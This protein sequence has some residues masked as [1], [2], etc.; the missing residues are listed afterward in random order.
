MELHLESISRSIRSARA[1][2]RHRAGA[3]PAETVRTAELLTSEL[4]TNAVKYGPPDGS[5]TV[6][7][8]N[9]SGVLDVSVSDESHRRPELRTPDPSEVGGRGLLMVDALASDWGVR[10]HPGDG[11][12]VWFRLRH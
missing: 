12:S 5:I 7:A 6:R 9:E 4:V 10:L 2:V 1:W 3:A 11:K 8:T